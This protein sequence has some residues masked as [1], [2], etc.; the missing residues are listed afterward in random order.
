MTIK[1]SVNKHRSL[2]L[3]LLTVAVL[4]VF[5]FAFIA[6][7]GT[8]GAIGNIKTVYAEEQSGL[9][10]TQAGLKNAID[11]AESGATIFI[12]DIPNYTAP[13]IINKSIVIKGGKDNGGQATISSVKSLAIFSPAGASGEGGANTVVYEDIKFECLEPLVHPTLGEMSTAVFFTGNVKASFV[14]CDFAGFA[15]S[16]G[17]VYGIYSASDSVYNGLTLNMHGCKFYGNTSSS[18]SL[19][20]SGALSNIK[21]NIDSC[22]FY[23]NTASDR[24]GAISVIGADL[25]VKN[26][27]FRDNESASG[28]AVCVSGGSTLKIENSVF[29]GNTAETGG[30]LYAEKTNIVLD[31]CIFTDN[32]SGEGGAAH[33]K[34]DAHHTQHI[35]NCSFYGNTALAEHDAGIEDIVIEYVPGAGGV[36]PDPDEP[37]KSVKI[38]FSSFAGQNAG[39]WGH[40]SLSAFGVLRLDKTAIEPVLPGAA[41]DFNA[42]MPFETAASAI[43]DGIGRIYYPLGEAIPKLAYQ[44]L[45]NNK[46]ANS[47]GD[48]YAGDNFAD[49]VTIR[50]NANGGTLLQNEL[51]C[52]YGQKI[53]LPAPEKTGYTFTGWYFDGERQ[54][55]TS[56]LIFGAGTASVDITALWTANVY[57]ATFTADGE[58]H[59]TKAQIFDATWDLNIPVPEKDGHKFIGWYTKQDGAGVIITENEFY[60]TDGDVSLYA[61]FEKVFPAWATALIIAGSVSILAALCYTVIALRRRKLL[62]AALTTPAVSAAVRP[63]AASV[64]LSANLDRL[65]KN[66]SLTPREKEII[67]MFIDNKTTVTISKELFI[68]DKTAKKHLRNV[69]EKLEVHSRDELLK[70]IRDS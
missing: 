29:Q 46:F 31:G 3:P 65:V 17:A 56:G 41:N 49:S 4:I 34:T 24:G 5:I 13:I 11:L 9:I 36:V 43:P 66:Y 44:S 10:T 18:G 22:E 35:V 52:S 54:V 57:T 25:T 7:D 53:S 67:E 14:N 61:L 30:A 69:Y 50:L 47:Y 39:L 45:M 32:S 26:S 51:S 2:H 55:N 15:A 63:A 40:T 58:I 27:V 38:I 42:V 19:Y 16:T 62:A 33:I 21:V 48:F 8:F 20:M 70:K 37:P 6:A 1:T 68:S 28:G 64:E 23:D 12:G 60:V 59:A